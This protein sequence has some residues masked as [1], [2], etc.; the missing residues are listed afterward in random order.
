MPDS[1]AGGPGTTLKNPGPGTWELCNG[2]GLRRLFFISEL[3][4]P[5]AWGG[6]VESIHCPHARDQL[7]GAKAASSLQTLVGLA[8][9]IGWWWEMGTWV[10]EWEFL[11][12]GG[13][14]WA[15]A[16]GEWPYI[17]EVPFVL[18]WHCPEWPSQEGLPLGN[19]YSPA[20]HIHSS[21]RL[22][23]CHHSCLLSPAYT[24]RTHTLTPPPHCPLNL[25]PP[26][27]YMLTSL[28]PFLFRGCW[29]MMNEKKQ[30][31]YLK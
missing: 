12:G 9:W 31:W 16:G 25:Q 4:K 19:E 24:Q 8:H 6:R 22:P 26:C 14:A 18:G 17:F 30:M 3:L 27:T 23:T 13:R 7:C 21:T 1:V 11:R 29:G 10:W 2:L 28:E 20:Q 5:F 15:G